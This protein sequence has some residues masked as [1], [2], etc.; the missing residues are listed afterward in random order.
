M[1][2][3]WECTRRTPCIEKSVKYNG[4]VSSSCLSKNPVRINTVPYTSPTQLSNVDVVV[5]TSDQTVLNRIYW[6]IDRCLRFGLKLFVGGTLK[7]QCFLHYIVHQ[8]CD[9]CNKS[10]GCVSTFSVGMRRL[11]ATYSR[12][13]YSDGDEL[14]GYYQARAGSA[15][16]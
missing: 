10:G 7:Q 2:S 8:I 11:D 9:S 13:N 16:S 14:R 6:D 12:Y 4:R 3:R 1:A 5:S 15:G